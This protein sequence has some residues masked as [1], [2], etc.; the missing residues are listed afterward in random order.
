MF[1]KLYLYSGAALLM[2]GAVFSWPGRG[3]LL[4][5][6]MLFLPFLDRKWKIPSLPQKRGHYFAWVVLA[7]IV[8][9]LLLIR[10]DK[11][12]F[13]FATLTLA[14]LPEEWFFR[15]WFMTRLGTG[16]QANIMASMFFSLIHL[17]IQGPTRA[18]LVFFPSLIFGWLYQRNRDLVMV[19]LVHALSNLGYV[20]YLVIWERKML[21]W[22]V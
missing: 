10:P 15:A 22:F 6:L 9:V 4:I 14:A 3:S 17:P 7:G 19:V 1:N 16:W 2:G 18:M 13:F 8:V 12:G 11:A 5:G 20:I 21:G